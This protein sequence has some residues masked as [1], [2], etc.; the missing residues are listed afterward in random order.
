MGRS[1]LIAVV[2]TTTMWASSHSRTRVVNSNGSGDAPTIQAAIDSAANGDTVLVAAGTYVENLNMIG[3]RLAL[4]GESGALATVV[5]GD[6]RAS[7]LLMSAGNV[8]GLTLRNGLTIGGGGGIGVVAPGPTVIRDCVIEDNV[9]GLVFDQGG[10]GGI[11]LSFGTQDVRVTNNVIRRNRTTGPGG[12]IEDNGVFNVFVGNT[13]DAN[14]ATLSGGGIYTAGSFIAN[15][16]ITGNVANISG[17]GIGIGLGGSVIRHNTIVGNRCILGS[18]AGI[19]GGQSIID[20]NIVAFNGPGGGVVEFGTPVPSCNDLW[21][22]DFDTIGPGNGNFAADPLFCDAAHA[23]YTLNENS[24]CAAANNPGC[25]LVGALGV[26][27]GST[28]AVPATWSRV[29]SLFRSSP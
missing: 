8:A 1:I 22:N 25:E 17:G 10:G 21:Q 26:D 24:P 6:D 29:K 18:G 11:Y 28:S 2:V 16:V 3:K 23:V 19:L 27:C 9:A 4:L 20:H 5:D 12:G 15:N 14:L 7:V 13:V